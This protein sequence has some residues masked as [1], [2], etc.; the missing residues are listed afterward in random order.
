MVTTKKIKKQK[1][2]FRKWGS[3]SFFIAWRYLFAKKSHNAINVVSGVSAAGVCVG[4]AALVCVLSVLNGFGS[5]V[6][7]MFSEF[8]PDLQITAVE[9][10]S[11]RCDTAAFVQ[12]RQMP[13]VAVFS[14]TIEETALIR[15]SEKQVPAIIKGVDTCFQALTNIDSIMFDGDFCVFDGAFERTVLG[16]GLANKMGIGAHFI[17]AIKIYS[18][19]RTGKVNMLRPEKSFNEAAVFIA[20]IFSVQQLVYDDQYMLVSLPLAQEL[21]EYEPHRVTA[22]ELK[23]ADSKQISLVQ[24][25]IRALLGDAYQV[26]DRYGQQA[27]FFRIMKIEKWMTCLLL[28]FILFIATFNIIGSLSILMIDK[29]ADIAILRSMGADN[30][31]IKRIFLYEGWL[32]S[33]CGAAV[34]IVLGLIVCLIQQYFG[35]LKLGNGG[36]YVINA[37]PVQVQAFDMLIVAVIVLLLGFFAAWYPTRRIADTH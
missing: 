30:R 29:Q 36:E 19:K 28:A 18:P 32:I 7:K 11:F 6:E 24:K 2:L 15:F 27:D 9:G 4:T 8:D 13:E 14:E 17:D 23:V 35:L 37:Y 3:V 34:G 16:V 26:C 22:V 1:S 20:G 31:M 10:K 12:I 21:F 33:I 5:L 25:R